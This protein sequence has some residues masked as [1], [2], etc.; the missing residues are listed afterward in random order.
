MAPALALADRSRTPTC[1]C[2]PSRF[3]P[4]AGRRCGRG[5]AAPGGRGRSRDAE[6][7]VLEAIAALGAIGGAKAF[8]AMLD[9]F[10][11]PVA[12]RARRGDDGR[13]ASGCRGFPAGVVECGAGSRLVGARQSRRHAGHVAAGRARAAL[14][15]LAADADTRVQAPALRALAQIGEPDLEAATVR[16]RST[17]RTSRCARRPRPWSASASPNGGASPSPGGVRPRRQRRDAD[18]PA[19]GPR[20]PRPIRH[21]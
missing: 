17:P 21:P 18:R 12:G 3:G 5:V 15:D 10:A 14:E 2:A 11:S 13:R 1:G 20:R 6:N 9:L 8:D 4:W 7:L 19:R 16:R